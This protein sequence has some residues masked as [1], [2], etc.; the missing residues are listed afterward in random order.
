MF[1]HQ[2]EKY[3]S[4]SDI[5]LKILWGLLLLV[6]GKKILFYIKFLYFHVLS[7]S[8]PLVERSVFN[9][10][11]CAIIPIKDSPPLEQED[12]DECN[13]FPFNTSIP[14]LL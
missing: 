1:F 11:L 5:T 4:H 2:A 10:P 13:S 8:Y 12:I 7:F 14:S 6:D 3:Y 9:R